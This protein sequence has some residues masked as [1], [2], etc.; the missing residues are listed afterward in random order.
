MQYIHV[1]ATPDGELKRLALTSGGE[2]IF[3][4][5]TSHLNDAMSHMV[6]NTVTNTVTHRELIL[7][8]CLR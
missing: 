2:C 4:S 6:K 3:A 7:H 5:D 8:D 1:N